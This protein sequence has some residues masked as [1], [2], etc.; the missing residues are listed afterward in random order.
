MGAKALGALT[1]DTLHEIRADLARNGAKLATLERKIEPL[2][3]Q[4]QN[5]QIEFDEAD[6]ELKRCEKRA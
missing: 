5:L 3:R 2:L 4:L 1:D 6:A